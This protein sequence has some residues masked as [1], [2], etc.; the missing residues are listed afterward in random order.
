MGEE[1]VAEVAVDWCLI[2]PRDGR[3]ER[4]GGREEVEER[5]CFRENGN[6]GRA[7]VQYI[8]RLTA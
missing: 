4:S 2:V 1:Q 7:G 5:R 6:G 3:K 8:P